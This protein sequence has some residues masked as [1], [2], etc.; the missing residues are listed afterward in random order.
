MYMCYNISG[1][2]TRSFC[3]LDVIFLFKCL[4]YGCKFD[5]RVIRTLLMFLGSVS[6][7]RLFRRKKAAYTKVGNVTIT[8]KNSYYSTLCYLSTRFSVSMPCIPFKLEYVEF[9]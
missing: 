2:W 9:L 7:E 1:Q 8:P 3:L 6:F 5:L 4:F